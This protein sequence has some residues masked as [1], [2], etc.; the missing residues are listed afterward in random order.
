MSHLL[1]GMIVFEMLQMNLI[2]DSI[3]FRSSKMSVL[4]Q[5]VLL[6]SCGI[7]GIGFIL[8]SSFLAVIWI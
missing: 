4:T 7:L 5:L 8:A 1:V 3:N 6:L 2:N